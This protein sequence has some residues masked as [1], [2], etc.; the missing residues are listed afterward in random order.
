MEIGN[1]EK[2]I[3]IGGQAITFLVVYEYQTV[4]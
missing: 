4:A 1:F 3:G 2:K